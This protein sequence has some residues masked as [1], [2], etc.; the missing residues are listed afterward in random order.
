M[1]STRLFRALPLALII[2]LLCAASASAAGTLGVNKRSGAALVPMAGKVVGTYAGEPEDGPPLVTAINCGAT[3]SAAIP[4]K[5]FCKP[6]GDCFNSNRSV[7]LSVTPAPGWKFTS[8]SGGCSGTGASCSVSMSTSKLVTANFVDEQAPTVELQGPAEN[9]E[10]RDSVAITAKASD[11]WAVTKVEWLLDNQ[12]VQPQ[13]D[14]IDVRGK[15]HGDHIKI[16]ARATDPAGGTTTAERTYVIDRKMVAA[17]TPP[18]PAEGS[19]VSAGTPEVAFTHD[20]DFVLRQCRT[21]GGEWAGC[22]TSYAPPTPKDGAYTVDVKV[23]DELGNE[24]P[25]TRSFKVDRTPPAASIATPGDGSYRRSGFTPDYTAT[26]AMTPK[27]SVTCA[28]DSGSF[29]ACGPVGLLPDGPHVFKVKA[30]DAAGHETIDTSTFTV[31]TAVPDVQITGGPA[32]GSI[33]DTPAATFDFAASDSSPLQ[34]ECRLDGAPYAPCG[35][36]GSHGFTDLAE[37]P[38]TFELRVTDAA[39]NAIERS[40]GFTVNAVRPSVAI[41]SGPADGSA[42]AETA[43]TFGFA[44]AGAVEVSCSLDSATTFRP[45]SGA[46]F[47]ALSRLGDGTH[48]F[49]VRARDEADEVV[50]AARTFD[51]DTSQPQTRIDAGPAEGSSTAA[52]DVTFAFS[53]SVEG[54]GFRCRFGAPGK[55]GPF[56]PC[57]GPGNTHRA[58]GLAPGAYVFEVQ[59]VNALGTPDA[60]PERRTFTLVKPP[61]PFT[62]ANFW[63]LHSRGRTGV[64][65][66]TVKNLPAG[67]RV[68]VRCKGPRCTFKR[69]TAKVVK[70]SAALKKLF[71]KRKLGAGAVVE[72]RI[73]APAIDGR[74]VRFRMRTGK[75]PKRVELCLPNATGKPTRC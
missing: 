19:W 59:A 2:A 61:A 38:H 6:T 57:S 13:A 55:L 42:V 20:S 16:A 29:V 67:A 24:A 9:A 62:V 48:V 32:Q 46:D 10:V 11:N 18:T 23:V 33:L 31:D 35:S 25:I 8:W 36:A 27:P 53:A 75:Y 28:V 17:F 72:I 26:D 58:V 3:C 14:T 37:G 1:T 69:D 66:L 70:G 68:E 52:R 60:S 34:H 4:D 15:Q 50:V 44:A 21:N 63:T 65:E 12:L 64:K 43:V 40:R 56:G 30:R 71:G 22:G 74:A 47:D 73:T 49:R 54:A 5:V 45:C 39:G 41:T 51:V 7:G